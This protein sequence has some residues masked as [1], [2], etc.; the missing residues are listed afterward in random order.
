MR[1]RTTEIP[2][3]EEINNRHNEANQ[4]NNSVIP[5]DESELSD[6]SQG[7]NLNSSSEFFQTPESTGPGLAADQNELCLTS[8]IV[9]RRL[10]SRRNVKYA[11][12]PDNS[13]ADSSMEQDPS[14][15]PSH[16]STK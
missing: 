4:G 12:S 14:Y 7:Q 15:V 6:R 8:P 1:N 3:G 5:L 10:R 16:N 2:E 13:S 11:L 9:P